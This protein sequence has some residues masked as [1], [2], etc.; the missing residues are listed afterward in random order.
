MPDATKHDQP[1]QTAR[2]REAL[3]SSKPDPL[4]LTRLLDEWM[5]G[6]ETEQRDTFEVLRRSLDEDRPEGYKLFL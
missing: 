1:F 5:R 6:D 2:Y 4:A 3:R